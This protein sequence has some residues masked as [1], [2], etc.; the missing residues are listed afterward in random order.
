M[1]NKIQLCNE[2]NLIWIDLEMTGLNPNFHRIIEIAVI[3]TD[4]SLNIL[5]EGT[6]IAIYQTDPYLKGMD[7][8]NKTTHTSSGLLNRVRNSNINEQIA[9][10]NILSFIKK[11]VPEKKSP[12]C[13]N[14]IGQDRRFLFRYMPL[15]E[16]YFHYH[17]IDVSTI[18]ELVSRWKPNILKKLKIQKTHQALEDI[19]SSILELA[20]YRDNLFFL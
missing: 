1:N 9:T 3:I 14:S 6:N 4:S 16:S 12:I 2:S 13:G 18:R 19:K 15:L 5:E 10:E 17:S 11:W 7:L 8:W 20:F